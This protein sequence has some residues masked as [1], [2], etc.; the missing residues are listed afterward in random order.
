MKNLYRK[1][2]AAIMSLVLIFSV[3]SCDI[4]DTDINTDPNNPSEAALDLLLANVISAN[5][6]T[7]GRG[8]IGL[9]S[10][11]SAFVGH[12]TTFDDFNLTNAT[13]NGTWNVLYSGALKDLHELVEAAEAQGNNP[14]NLAVGQILKAYYWSLMVDLWGDIP[15]TEAFQGDAET[16]IKEPAFDDDA[17]IYADLINLCDQAVANLALESSV[18]IGGDLIYNATGAAGKARW[19]KAAKTL[20]LRLLLQTRNVNDVAAEIQELVSEGDLILTAADDFQYNYPTAITPDN[21]HPWY[22]DAYAGGEAS[23]DYFGHQFMYE[24]LRDRDPR[25][26]FYFHRQTTTLLDAND[27]TQRQTMPCSQRDDCVY[28][29]FPVSPLV[30]NGVFGVSPDALT[31]DQVAYLAGVFGRDRSDPS[32]VPNDN[33]IRTTVGAYPAGGVFDAVAGSGGGNKGS[34]AGIFPMITSWM[35]KFY[36][37]EAGITL[38]VDFSNIA[39]SE[40]ELLGSAITDQMAKVWAVGSNGQTVETNEANWGTAYDWPITFNTREEFVDEVEADYPAGGTAS[41]RLNYV[42]KQA[43][44][45]N[46]GNGYETY[47]AFRRTGFPN[48]LQEPL[49]LPRNFALRLPYAQ[50]EL[51]LNSNTPAIVYDSP[52]AAVFWDTLQYQF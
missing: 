52:S 44:F 46:F 18:A 6:F 43:W 33:P 25:F 39:D 8:T 19:R 51:N 13:W 40:S 22:Q 37:L 47:N 9:N 28:G 50:D 24:M 15:Y 35:T 20:K 16:P 41:Q 3:S 21:R 27:P 29:Y 48:D 7:F 1:G 14:H 31:D 38:G 2:L 36:I 34:G 49:E 30:T 45:A 17:A 23:F 10:T 32:G 12:T 4:F 26:P 5:S 11:L 42:L